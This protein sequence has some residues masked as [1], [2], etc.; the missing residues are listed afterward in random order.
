MSLIRYLILLFFPLFAFAQSFEKIAPKVSPNMEGEIFTPLEL[1]ESFQDQVLLER[2]KGIIFVESPFKITSE[3]LNFTGIKVEGED[4]VNTT[5]FICYMER[6]LGAPLTFRLLNEIDRAATQFYKEKGYPLVSVIIPADQD[7]TLGVIQVII[8][9]GRLGEIKE[10]RGRYFSKINLKRKISTKPGEIILDQKMYSD[11]LFL[12]NNPFY[13]V[14]M[15]YEAGK[16]FGRSDLL[17]RGHIKF[18]FRIFG[19]YE[20]SGNKLIS[21]SRLLSGFNAG[22]LAGFGDQLNAQFITAPDPKKWWGISSTYVAPLP[23]RDTLN[24]FVSYSKTHPDI[25]KHFFSEGKSFQFFSYYNFPFKTFQ[26]YRE[27]FLFGYEFKRTNNFLAFDKKRI[28]NKSIDISQFAFSYKMSLEESLGEFNFEGRFVV[29]PGHMTTYNKDLYFAQ[30]RKGA[31]STYTYLQITLEQLFYL[32]NQFTAKMQLFSQLTTD[33][34]LPSEQECLTGYLSVRGYKE[35]ELTA[36]R[37]LLLKN[38]FYFPAINLKGNLK[39]LTFFDFGWGGGGVNIDQ[40]RLSK[41][42]A[43]LGLGMRYNLDDYLTLRFDLGFQ[44]IPIHENGSRGAFP[45]IGIVGAF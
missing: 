11:Y 10:E 22:N 9:I 44:L 5:E 28:F 21:Y 14:D 33:H 29:S 36:D 45:H 16:E 32:P 15:I 6:Y 37:A 38:D 19:G 30:Q 23:W 31:D 13:K 18:P 12:N 20:N 25:E 4:L 27:E 7:I 8:T 24:L 35:C 2:L 42:I 1:V 41:K 26:N 17:L 43:S 39:F 3:K 40:K 34:L